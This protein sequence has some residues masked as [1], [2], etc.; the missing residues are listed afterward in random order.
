[1]ILVWRQTDSGAWSWH[2]DA[3][4]RL[5]C[6]SVAAVRFSVSLF[7][8]TSILAESDDYLLVFLLLYDAQRYL[9]PTLLRSYLFLLSSVSFSVSLTGTMENLRRCSLQ[10]WAPK[11]SRWRSRRR[12]SRLWVGRRRHLDAVDSQYRLGTR[13]GSHT[14]MLLGGCCGH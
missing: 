9:T 6:W 5:S 4:E 2:A 14:E 8:N 10:G 7:A 11:I 1:M 12:G 13:E 3:G